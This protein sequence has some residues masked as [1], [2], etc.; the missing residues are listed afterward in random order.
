MGYFHVKNRNLIFIS[1]IDYYLCSPSKSN[2]MKNQYF[3]DVRD[4]FKY[5]LIQHLISNIDCLKQLFFVAMLTPDDNSKEGNKVSFN[6]AKA[7][8]NNTQLVNFLYDALVTERKLNKIISYFKSHNIKTELIEE[9]FDHNQRKEYF[10]N[11]TKGSLDKSIIFFDPDN[12]LEVKNNNEKHLLFDELKMV[13]NN[14]DDDSVV[15]I[16]QHFPRVK[17]LQ[18]IELR[19]KE[20]V[21][22]TK[23]Q[24]TFISDNE[25]VFFFIAKN[26]YLLKEI[27]NNIR[28]YNK[29]Y[30]KLY[31]EHEAISVKESQL[32]MEY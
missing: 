4:L 18:Y 32:I 2:G 28:Q 6:K 24:C 13:I 3:G 12:G 5:D 25:I 31:G 8:Y 16:Y 21:H 7:G 30:P 22:N 26:N 11:I 15:M 9:I 27:K 1:T 14:M 17:R 23:T 20:I 29:R 10:Q 19:K